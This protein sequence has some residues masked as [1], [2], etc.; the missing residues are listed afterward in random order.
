M[1]TI[2]FVFAVVATPREAIW[3]FAAYA[4]I[5]MGVASG[6]GIPFAVLGRRLTIELPFIVVAL[7]LPFIGQGPNTT[8]FGM[9]VSEPGLWGAWNIVVKGTM[10][11]A[12][13]AILVAT[14]NTRDLLLGLERLRVPR[15]FTSIMGFMMRYGELTAGELR[16]CTSHASP[17]V[18]IRIGSGRH[19]W[20]RRRPERSSSA[21]MN[22]VS[23]Y[24]SRW[25]RVGTGPQSRRHFTE[26]GGAS[27]GW[28]RWRFLRRELRSR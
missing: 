3:A 27:N 22:A 4:L 24:T 16:E 14:T 2:G 17:A 28:W 20:W 18:T 1:A 5:L 23:V 13:A 15:T 26:R 9:S 8:V 7:V 12:A 25:R 19:A 11:V 21:R 10:G 6:R